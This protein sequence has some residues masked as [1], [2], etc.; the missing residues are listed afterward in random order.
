MHFC[1]LSLSFSQND[2]SVCVNPGPHFTH[3]CF[4]LWRRGVVP[5]LLP[6]ATCCTLLTQ[7]L[8]AIEALHYLEGQWAF[9][10]AVPSSS[11]SVRVQTVRRRLTPFGK[12][13]GSSTLSRAGKEAERDLKSLSSLSSE[14]DQ[15]SSLLAVSSGSAS[16]LP[17]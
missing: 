17:R 13:V 10:E 8:Q 6:Q 7:L 9:H 4:A 16:S 3:I 2:K 15:W 5:W 12:L 11:H 1:C 14:Q